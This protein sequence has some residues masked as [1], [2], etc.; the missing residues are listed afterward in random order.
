[1]FVI[2]LAQGNL[3]YDVHAL[4][5]SFFPGEEV[6]VLTPETGEDKRSE[7]TPAVQMVISFSS[8]GKCGAVH[9]QDK[10]FHWKYSERENGLSLTEKES[11]KRFFYQVLCYVTHKTLPW[12]SLTGIRP[13]KICYQMLEEGKSEDEIVQFMQKKYDVS[14]EKV[15]L[16]LGIAKRERRLLSGMNGA[17]GESYSLYVGIPFCPTTCLYCSFTSYPIAKYKDKSDRYIDCL[18]EEGKAS[19]DILRQAPKT[20]YIG[21]GTPTSLDA[22]QLERLLGGLQEIYGD[23][24]NIEFTVEA[25]RADSITMPK[26]EVLKRLGV[27][28]I[29]VNPQ[30][31]NQITLDRIG[32]KHSVRQVNEAYYAAREVGFDNINMDIILGL[33]GEGEQE[34]RHTINEI[35]S[36]A[37]DSLTVHSLAIKRASRMKEWVKEHGTEELQNSDAMMQIAETGAIQLGMK[38]YYLYRQK[39]M[40]GNFENV[41]YAAPGK[42]SLYNILIMEEKQTIVALGAGSITK[43]V[44]ADGRIE[45]RENV[46]DVDMYCSQ[47]ADMIERKREIL[48]TM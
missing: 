9:W 5:G 45:R 7:W 31:M 24:S 21:G 22:G 36:L 25:G 26:L 43:K 4:T 11:F 17:G 27:N 2:D 13:T 38:P 6:H 29:S 16:G 40:S 1:M 8:Q 42:E 18:L 48:L 20:V 39:N 35:V 12:G 46:K 14:L 19:Y 41:G 33:P 37:P 3:E 32:R 34:V 44:C 10:I 23:F 47:L 28:R 30:T 15:R